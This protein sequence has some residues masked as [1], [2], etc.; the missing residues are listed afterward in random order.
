[1]V[2]SLRSTNNKMLIKIQNIPGRYLKFLGNSCKGHDRYV[3]HALL[4]LMHVLT[5][6][7]TP[8]SESVLAHAGRFALGSDAFT[9]F[10]E[11]FGLGHGARTP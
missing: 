1:M 3:H 10:Y 7:I 2:C 9:H 4:D 6:H 8:Q 5:V 11:V